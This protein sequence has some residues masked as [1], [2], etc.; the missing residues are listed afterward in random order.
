[1]TNQPQL[2][3]HSQKRP[4]AAHALLLLLLS[5]LWRQGF[6]EALVRCSHALAEEP[7]KVFGELAGAKTLVEGADDFDASL[8]LARRLEPAEAFIARRYDLGKVLVQTER[9][10]F[11]EEGSKGRGSHGGSEPLYE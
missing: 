6:E 5:C 10:D 4:V 1:H 2:G 3:D 8:H 9:P 11:L 7:S